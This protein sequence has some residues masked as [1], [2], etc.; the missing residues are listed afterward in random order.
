MSLVIILISLCL[1]IA[2]IVTERKNPKM[3]DWF[4]YVAALAVGLISICFWEALK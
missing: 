4:F 2:I 1:V 3:P